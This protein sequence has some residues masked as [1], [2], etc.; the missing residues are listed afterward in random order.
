MPEHFLSATLDYWLLGNYKPWAKLVVCLLPLDGSGEKEIAKPPSEP[1]LDV[2][3]CVRE[4]L[5]GLV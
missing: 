5:V 3:L 2:V 1:Q 4:A